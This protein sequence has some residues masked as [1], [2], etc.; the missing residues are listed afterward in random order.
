MII[1]DKIKFSIRKQGYLEF[2]F[3]VQYSLKQ[4]KI[5]PIH[6][7]AFLMN[8]AVMSIMTLEALFNDLSEF[9][10]PEIIFECWNKTNSTKERFR[11]SIDLLTGQK[12]EF[13]IADETTMKNIEIKKI[14]I[15]DFFEEGKWYKV[16]ELV[17][18]RNKIVHRKTED[19]IS[20]IDGDRT[21]NN[22]IREKWDFDSKLIPSYIDDLKCFFEELKDLLIKSIIDPINERLISRFDLSDNKFC[23][24]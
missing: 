19:K 21:L 9:Y 14:D 18:I 16:C 4:S 12:G 8:A 6:K 3:I 11:S 7:E 22:S 20:I 5:D 2:W 1:S 17:R 15:G 23:K 24:I 13:S 10:L